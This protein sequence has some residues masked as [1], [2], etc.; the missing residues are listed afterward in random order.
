MSDLPPYVPPGQAPQQGYGFTNDPNQQMMGGGMSP[1]PQQQ[2]GNGLAVAGMVL[3]IIAIVLCWVPFL[4]QVLALLAI[5]FGAIGTGKANKIGGKGKG[6]AMA[7]LIMGIIGMILGI[8]IIVMAMSAA[9][10]SYSYSHY[11]NY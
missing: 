5:I 6:M 10:H 4:D 1:Q 3:G 2:Q 9:R 11:G 7:G 8:A